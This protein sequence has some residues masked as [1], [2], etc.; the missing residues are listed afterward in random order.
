M[1]ALELL[2]LLDIRKSLHLGITEI[3]DTPEI[4]PDFQM[5]LLY[6]N[7]NSLSVVYIIENV[8]NKLAKNSIRFLFGQGKMQ[9][10]EH[11]ENWEDV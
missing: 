6:Y 3:T 9:E 4:R 8:H 11:E 1:S 5:E 10:G 7:G 2:L